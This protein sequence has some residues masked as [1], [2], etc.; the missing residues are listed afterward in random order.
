MIQMGRNRI[1]REPLESS[2]VRLFH[3]MGERRIETEQP[4]LRVM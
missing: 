3:S 4:Q 2:V 1:W